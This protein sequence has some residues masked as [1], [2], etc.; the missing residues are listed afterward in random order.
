LSWEGPG[1]DSC[2]SENGRLALDGL[3][4][5]EI[6]QL[7]FQRRLYGGVI[8]HVFDRHTDT[9]LAYGEA[10]KISTQKSNGAWTPA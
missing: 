6:E 1:L 2:R 8:A 7:L 4:F 10:A 5:L 9:V 3:I